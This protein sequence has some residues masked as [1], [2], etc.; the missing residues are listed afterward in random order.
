MSIR[1]EFQLRHRLTEATFE[2]QE[3]AGQGDMGQSLE[4]LDGCEWRRIVFP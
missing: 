3:A 1:E 2:V 4:S